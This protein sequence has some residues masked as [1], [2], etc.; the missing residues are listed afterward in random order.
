ML[1]RETPSVKNHYVS[2]DVRSYLRCSE[3]PR[4]PPTL[5]R[6]LLESVSSSLLLIFL[7]SRGC[8]VSLALRPFSLNNDIEHQ[9]KSTALQRMNCLESRNV[10]AL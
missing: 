8:A 9:L 5:P 3:G 6:G 7:Y 2:L 4:E 1:S 10:S